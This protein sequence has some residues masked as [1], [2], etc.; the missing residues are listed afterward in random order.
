M[1]ENEVLLGGAGSRPAR[2]AQ[3]ASAEGEPLS[4][5]G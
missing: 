1:A 4:F 5:K 3:F 2:T